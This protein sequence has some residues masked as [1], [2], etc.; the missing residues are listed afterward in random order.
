LSGGST[1]FFVKKRGGGGGGGMA[2][3]STAYVSNSTYVGL[4]TYIPYFFSNQANS[5]AVIH[6]AQDNT[7]M[8][9]KYSWILKITETQKF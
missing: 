6:A 4:A 1:F 8:A 3:V 7:N 5:N 2:L 9:R